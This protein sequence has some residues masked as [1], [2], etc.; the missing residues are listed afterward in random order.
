MSETPATEAVAESNEEGRVLPLVFSGK[1]GEYFGIWIVNVALTIVTLGIYSAWAKVRTNRYFYG[2]TR[3]DGDAFSYHARPMQSLIARIIV[4]AVL[5]AYNVAIQIELWLI[6]PFIIAFIFLFPWLIARSLRFQSR[7]T[8]WRNVSF[9]FQTDYWPAFVTFILVPLITVFTLGLG[10]PIATKLTQEWA[11]N[12]F[13]FGDR[14][15]KTEL[16]LGS[17]Y[18]LFF[19]VFF[20]GVF[21]YV[22][23][24][25]LMA[26]PAILSEVNGDGGPTMTPLMMIGFAGAYVMLIGVS[27][28]IL[29]YQAGVRNLVFSNLTLDDKHEFQSTISKRKYAWIILSNLIATIFTLGLLIPWAKVRLA[30]FLADNTFVVPGGPLDEFVENVKETQ[31]VIGEEYVDIE[32]IDIGIGL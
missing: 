20:I 13:S 6:I 12:R 19:M 16:G 5:V 23:A 18:K 29:V 22:G 3:L 27:L 17:L 9:D 31:G 1:A 21:L 10:A 26:G 28:L 25:A 15:F 14:P 30:R 8:R 11:Y 24:I 2:S 7:V 4:V 32:G